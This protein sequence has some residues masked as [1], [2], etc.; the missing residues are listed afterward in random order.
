MALYSN[1]VTLAR[2]TVPPVSIF[3]EGEKR[4]SHHTSQDNL[5]IR[6]IIC[7]R[8]FCTLGREMSYKSHSGIIRAESRYFCSLGLGGRSLL[9]VVSEPPQQSRLKLKG[10]RR[11]K[12][13]VYVCGL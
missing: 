1:P 10:E 3:R 13:M 9:E 12:T 2:P 4:L 11:G 7:E 6:E 5:K 8:E